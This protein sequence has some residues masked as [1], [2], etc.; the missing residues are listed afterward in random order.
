MF[1][2]NTP[3]VSQASTVWNTTDRND[4]AAFRFSVAI[5]T[6]RREV[7]Y[8]LRALSMAAQATGNNRLPCSGQTDRAWMEGQGR[9][10]FW[11]TA[12]E[13][14]AKFEEWTR[15]FLS[16]SCSIGPERDNDLLPPKNAR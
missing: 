4:R 6:K 2:P 13:Y 12:P 10:K 7:L 9:A 8:C 5:H 3:I 11:F 16:S 14:R 15:E 1:G